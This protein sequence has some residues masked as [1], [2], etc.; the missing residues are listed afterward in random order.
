MFYFGLGLDCGTKI[1]IDLRP[2]L[3]YKDLDLFLQ[4]STH[5]HDSIDLGFY[6][7]TRNSRLFCS[8]RLPR[9]ERV[10]A[11]ILVSIDMARKSSTAIIGSSR[12]H[13]Q[14]K[15]KIK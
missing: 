9:A 4:A 10:I 5:S 12:V 11:K 13:R 6:D 14:K 15:R 8:N 2:T 3:W 1:F 7:S